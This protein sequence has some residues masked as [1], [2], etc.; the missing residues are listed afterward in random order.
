METK[1]KRKKLIS[2]PDGARGA[3]VLLRERHRQLPLEQ[4][5][6]GRV[7]RGKHCQ[8]GQ[9]GRRHRRERDGSSSSRVTLPL[10]SSPAP[11][12]PP[13]LFL[14]IVRVVKEAVLYLF[15]VAVVVFVVVAVVFLVFV[16][17]FVVG[18]VVRVPHVVEGG[19]DLFQ[20]LPERRA[21][22]GEDVAPDKERRVEAVRQPRCLRGPRPRLPRDDGLRRRRRRGRGRRI[23]RRR[24]R[25]PLPAEEEPRDERAAVAAAL[26]DVDDAE[27]ALADVNVAALRR[28]FVLICAFSAP[29]AA[30][31]LELFRA[32]ESKPA[33]VIRGRAGEDYLSRLNAALTSVRGVNRTDVLALGAAFGTAAGVLSAPRQ[34]L[35]AVPGVGPT[36]ARRLADAFHE[37]FFK[38]YSASKTTTAG[39]TGGGKKQRTQARLVVGGGGSA[40]RVVAPS[41]DAALQREQGGGGGEAGDQEEEE[42][43]GGGDDDDEVFAV[44]GGAVPAGGGAG[45]GLE[46]EE[47]EDDD[48]DD[49]NVG[50]VVD[51]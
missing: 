43:N 6:G 2:Y 27:P 7:P 40:L 36:K 13:S 22:G 15:A 48:D 38:T 1:K 20:E 14:D 4:D 45:A 11:L 39:G 42:P 3:V 23:R 26:V 30:R 21:P 33:D 35:A 10:L 50:I 12:T 16:L 9:R 29:E 34:A 47:I 31:Y 17:V 25:E 46:V 49:D 18:I 5:H 37:P 19:V 8:G 51:E 32:F 24:S 44:E 41:A 28:G